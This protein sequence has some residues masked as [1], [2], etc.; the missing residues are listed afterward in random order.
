MGNLLKEMLIGTILGDAHL[1]RTG[2]NRAFLTFEQSS[3]K[4]DYLN[5]I[6][7]IINQEDLALEEPRSYSR[8]DS[9]YNI[10]NQS[11]YF[12]TKSLE[13]LKPF[14]DMFL[15]KDNKK[16]IPVNIADYL[17]PRSLAFWIM[18][19]GQAVKKGGV[20]LCTDS[21]KSEEVSLLRQ[22][23]ENKFAIT[24]SIHNKK[25]ST[26]NYYERIYIN[27]SSLELLKP[28]LKT[29][30]HDSMLYKINEVVPR[31]DINQLES[32]ADSVSDSFDIGDI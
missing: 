2:L 12:R 30:F 27:K 25:G 20:T 7:N 32:E 26:G 24:T 1:G 17:T 15:D 31:E 23:L 21:F 5:H 11:L 29:H 10:T 13:E 8:E 4:S 28:E 14:A 16:T 22:A 3:K 6:Y 18:D 19:D 9:R